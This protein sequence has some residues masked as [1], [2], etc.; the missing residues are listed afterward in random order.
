LQVALTS[1]EPKLL[2]CHELN[3]FKKDKL[4][5]AAVSSLFTSKK[6]RKAVHLLL[7][8]VS[9]KNQTHQQ[10][11]TTMAHILT[12]IVSLG[13]H[14]LQLSRDPQDYR[15]LCCPHCKSA[16]LWQHGFYLHKA[17]RLPSSKRSNDSIQI[18]RYLCPSCKRSCSTLP[19][20]LPPRR[21][22]LWSIQQAVLLAL[23]K[24]HSLN[25]VSQQ[26]LPC[27]QTCR[28][29]W[30]QLQSRFALHTDCLRSRFAVLGRAQSFGDFWRAC[31]EKMPL[32]QAMCLMHQSGLSIP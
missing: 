31:L 19:E 22:Y 10:K 12:G 16:K 29:W 13:Q 28:R 7:V 26:H 17:E 4:N 1:L 23:L 5:Y 20:C 3:Q 25:D 6:K 27:R 8:F 30:R 24:G 2:S 15:P 32:S 9:T 11:R 18:L 21:W 14:I